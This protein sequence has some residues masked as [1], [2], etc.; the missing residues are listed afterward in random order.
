MGLNKCREGPGQ[1]WNVRNS[2]Q[3]PH[4]LHWLAVCWDAVFFLFSEKGA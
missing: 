4:S 2:Q 1:S 3:G